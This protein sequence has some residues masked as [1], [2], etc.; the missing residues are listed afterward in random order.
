MPATRR[1]ELWR[2]TAIV[3]FRAPS[4]ALPDDARILQ[5]TMIICRLSRHGGQ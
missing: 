3:Q 2:Q 4:H 1:E 5:H